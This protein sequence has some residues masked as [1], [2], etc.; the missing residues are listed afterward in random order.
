[1]KV[2]LSSSKHS[3]RILSFE[4]FEVQKDNDLESTNFKQ[5]VNLE[6]DGKIVQKTLIENNL[7]WIL[8]LFDDN[9]EE[10]IWTQIDR[11]MFSLDDKFIKV[12]IVDSSLKFT[13]YELVKRITSERRNL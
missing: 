7:L 5:F 10:I 12:E 13:F 1:M 8:D 2:K 6:Q 4:K 3:A 9:E 11:N